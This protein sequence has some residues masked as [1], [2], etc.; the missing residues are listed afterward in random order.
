MPQLREETPE[1][2]TE[3]TGEQHVF[4]D[5]MNRMPGDVLRGGAGQRTR[6]AMQH[7]SAPG[8]NRR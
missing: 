5:E 7:G 6:T 2:A 1:D 8:R 3:M 4:K